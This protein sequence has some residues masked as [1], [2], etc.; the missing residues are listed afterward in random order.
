MAVLQKTSAFHITA[1]LIDTTNNS[2]QHTI[3]WGGGGGGN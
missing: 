1:T 3:F 2:K